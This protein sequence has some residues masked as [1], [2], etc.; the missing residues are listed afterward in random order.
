MK[1]HSGCVSRI[2]KRPFGAVFIWGVKLKKLIFLLLL[3]PAIAI[4]VDFSGQIGLEDLNLGTGTFTRRTSTGGTVTLTQINGT[5]IGVAGTG[6]LSWSYLID[7]PTTLAGYGITDALTAIT[8]NSI[9]PAKLSTSEGAIDDTSLFYRSDGKWMS[10]SVSFQSQIDAKQNLDA[11]LTTLSTPTAWRLFYSNSTQAITELAF[12][13]AD[14]YLK[15][16]GASAAPTW[17]ALAYPYPGA[18]VPNSTG[19]AWGTSYTVGTAA[20]NLVQLNGSAQISA[21]L[22]P[23]VATATALAANGANCSA[24]Q[25]PLGVS[26]SGAAEGCWTPTANLNNSTMDNT[27]ITRGSIDNAVVGGT[28]PAAGAFSSLTVGGVSNTE[29]SYLN[30]LDGNIQDLLDLKRALDNLT[31][32]GSAATFDNEV[33]ATQFNTTCSYDDN[34]CG[35]NIS[36]SGPPATAPSGDLIWDNTAKA[37][38]VG[39]STNFDVI[40]PSY[41]YY[42]GAIDQPVAGDNT[43]FD[44]PLEFAQVLD[45][46]IFIVQDNTGKLSGSAND[47][48][49]LNFS[50]CSEISTHTCTDVFTSA[51][52]PTGAAILAPDL[53][54]ATPSAG[55]YIRISIGANSNMTNKKLYIRIRY[56]EK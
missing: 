36:V 29:F 33:T 2:G 42:R 12:G 53:D 3:I 44:G 41:K 54:N 28:T 5:N 37:L 47:N 55:D 50:Y 38:K 39:N 22:I 15:S 4:G 49:T 16:N 11:D 25:A 7:T 14:T 34:T 43:I 1:S 56:K 21:S 32:T 8:D 19:S 13:T 26:A 9:T 35:L 30:G 46:V 24:G 48:V 17:G 18:G 40:A 31:F 51:P 20:S 23:N 52:T 6:S 45:N 10:P 27:I